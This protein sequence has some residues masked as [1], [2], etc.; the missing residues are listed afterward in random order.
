M[1]QGPLSIGVLGPVEVRA[2][3]TAR[4]VGQPRRRALLTVLALEAGRA[5]TTSLL[6]E[7]LW[8]DE[9]PSDPRTVLQ[10]HVSKLRRELAPDRPPGERADLLRTVADGYLLDVDPS[11]VDAHRLAELVDAG[12]ARLHADPAEALAHLDAASA[13]W[14]GRPLVDLADGPYRAAE[15]ARLHELHLTARTVRLACLL[16]LDR[17]DEVVADVPALLADHPLHE[18][19]TAALA[20]ALYRLGRQG[21][22]LEQHRALRQRLDR[23]L[24]VAP[25]PALQSLELAILRQDEA[26]R[27]PYPLRALLAPAVAPEQTGSPSPGRTTGSVGGR[28]GT[29]PL[30][31][32]LADAGP[33]PLVG[34]RDEL[35]R[36]REAWA[37]TPSPHGAS[38]A[39]VRGD[40][41]VG[42]SRLVA[43]L[44]RWAHRQGATVLAGRCD[45]DLAVPYQPVAEAL[46]HHV[47]HEAP[48]RL[49]PLLGPAP[50]QLARI[51]PAV[52]EA[53]SI[54]PAQPVDPETDRYRLLEAVTGWLTALAAHAP[55]MLVL[56]DLQWTPASTLLLVRHVLGRARPAERLLVVAT[57]R[58][59][60]L[61][62]D[63]RRAAVLTELRADSATT[64]LP[65]R[66]LDA[67][68]VAELVRRAPAHAGHADDEHL[69]GLLHAHTSGNPLFV[70][71]LL[72]HHDDLPA[73][74]EAL[75]GEGP[76]ADDVEVPGGVHA[77][78]TRRLQRFDDATRE[79]LRTAALA[80]GDFEVAVV[81]GATSRPYSEV[82]D[83]VDAGVRAGLLREVDRPGA[84]CEFTHDIVRRAI[85]AGLTRARRRHLHRRVAD[86]LEA[87]HGERRLGA[88][89][90]HLRRA[91]DAV[92]PERA[93][94][95]SLRAAEQARR[96]AAIDEADRHCREAIARL[97]LERGD[98]R[99]TAR[100]RELLGD[101][102]YATGIDWERGLE[103]L[104]RARA[105][106]ERLDEHR[107]AA[108]ARS[109][110]ARNL[111]TFLARIDVHRAH[112]EVDA[113]L[114]VLEPLG[115]SVPLAYALLARAAACGWDLRTRRGLAAAQRA[116]AIGER[117]G[118]A[119][120]TANARMLV[121]QHTYATGA[122][123]DGERWMLDARRDAVA[124][125]D[126]ILAWIG[127]YLY[128][129]CGNLVYDPLLRAD[130]V[131]DELASDRYDAT[132]GLRATLRALLCEWAFRRGALREAAELAAELPRTEMLDAHREHA[133][134]RWE[135]SLTAYRG[136]AER[137][138]AVGDANTGL[139]ALCFASWACELR[140]HR[141]GAVAHAERAVGLLP[142]DA[143][144]WAHLWSRTRL[145]TA[146]AH[147]RP[148]AAEPHVARCREVLVAGEDHGGTVGFLAIAEGELATEAD[149]A[150]R[151][152][153]R[154]RA[155]CRRTGT[156][157]LEAEVLWRWAARSG[158]GELFDEAAALYQ[159]LGYGRAW[160]GHVGRLREVPTR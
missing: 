104:D 17:H 18:A 147:V 115:D 124:G 45:A 14:R 58:D 143:P 139:V 24:G 61:P 69:V 20:V 6:A 27:E 85:A 144:T 43:E 26:L 136:L 42:K 37:A 5:C 23:E 111:S 13:L 125:G 56:E 46:A 60:D 114:E 156:A 118:H 117:L 116:L 3:A 34:R 160:T 97:D 30:P 103:Q 137:A 62:A 78:V 101:T 149:A 112:R 54:A 92:D 50:A 16:A 67:H 134:G 36:L 83:A 105:D 133:A 148:S 80:G 107:S 120:V 15:S 28:R 100:L 64:D 109:R 74:L 52:A 135:Q 132:P 122:L 35:A 40:A 90:V 21:D 88:V 66:G 75:A 142:H 113:A 47:R 71:E 55:T 51:H 73:A 126:P 1:S 129:L 77:L 65:L 158:R 127:G 91:G 19:P 53:L 11:V 33:A 12:R 4:S 79:I 155:V 59:T 76:A 41:G 10:T 106:L 25:S 48:E 140:G 123:R 81:V 87:V 108:K 153:D 44:G 7:A 39:L 145:A 63:G 152:F 38:L 99:S 94:T 151:A 150:D 157:P 141:D 31:P 22:A 70:E 159:R 49:A 57:C 98:A 131:R 128:A 146:L 130:W 93:I 82:A 8:A 72:R 138:L 89:A 2:S 110:I 95:A 121:G 29:L 86:A 96:H 84:S 32:Q 68:A 102:M 9:P 119:T 154:A